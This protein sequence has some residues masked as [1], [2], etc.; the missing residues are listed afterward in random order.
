[1][2]ELDDEGVVEHLHDRL[3]ILYDVFFLILADESF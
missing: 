2:V 1:M 3:L